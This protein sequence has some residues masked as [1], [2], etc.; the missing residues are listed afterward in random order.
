MSCAYYR[1]VYARILLLSPQEPITVLMNQDNNIYFYFFEYSNYS[2]RKHPPQNDSLIVWRLVTTQSQLH[3]SITMGSNI[4][5]FIIYVYEFLLQLA[6]YRTI[7]IN[8][9]KKERLKT[10]AQ[11]TIAEC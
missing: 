2:N 5:V 3:R 8:I 6:E 10:H 11:S 9:L 1:P 7:E 4:E